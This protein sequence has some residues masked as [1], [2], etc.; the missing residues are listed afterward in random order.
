MEMG[1]AAVR[2]SDA[3]PDVGHAKAFQHSQ[4]VLSIASGRIEQKSWQSKDLD[5]AS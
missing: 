1:L 3:H 4:K 5:C 2:A